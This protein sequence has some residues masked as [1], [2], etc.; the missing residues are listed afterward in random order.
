VVI[1]VLFHKYYCSK[2]IMAETAV[3]IYAVGRQRPV[4]RHHLNIVDAA[5]MLEQQ[6]YYKN[7]RRANI[8]KKSGQKTRGIH[9]INVQLHVL[10][11]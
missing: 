11:G 3:V 1:S 6:Q 9:K 2:I 8:D 7:K 10:L 5:S 4:R